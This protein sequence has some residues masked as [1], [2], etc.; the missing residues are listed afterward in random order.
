MSGGLEDLR[1]LG[2][3]AHRLGDGLGLPLPPRSATG[4]TGFSSRETTVTVVGR[5]A[6]ARSATGRTSA[7]RRRACMTSRTEG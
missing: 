1:L 4:A 3:K 5:P 2:Q 7:P 6:A